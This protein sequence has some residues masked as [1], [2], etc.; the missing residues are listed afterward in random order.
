MYDINNIEL[1]EAVDNIDLELDLILD[2]SADNECGNLCDDDAKDCVEELNDDLYDDDEVEEMVQIEGVINRAYRIPFKIA[3]QLQDDGNDGGGEE[4]L[5]RHGNPSMDKVI[6]AEKKPKD[7]RYFQKDLDGTIASINR[8]RDLI[9]KCNKKGD[10]EETKKYYKSIKTM[11]IDKGITVKDCDL[12]IKNLEKSK[13]MYEKR[14]KELEDAAANKKE[15]K[16]KLT[17]ESAELVDEFDEYF[18][19]EY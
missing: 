12:T 16:K 9:D 5:K 14:A 2:E 1:E 15:S 8:V 4:L 3:K 6:M 13:A 7:I 11:Y 19:Y 17:K 10:C 18:D